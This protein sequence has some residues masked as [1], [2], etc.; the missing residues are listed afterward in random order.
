MASPTLVE[1]HLAFHQSHPHR[2]AF[3]L[4]YSRWAHEGQTVTP[5]MRW[6]EEDGGLQF[7]YGDLFQGKQPTWE[8]F[9]TSNLS[10]KTEL[11]RA[12]PFSES[13]TRPVME[14]IELG[15][16]LA[17]LGELEMHFLPEALGEHI[18][19]TDVDRSCRRMIIAGY[20]AQELFRAWPELEPGPPPTS[21]K[22]R[23]RRAILQRGIG[24]GLL[25]TVT[26]TLTRF[27]CPNHC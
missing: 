10:G 6:L 18:H 11:L 15:Y 4:G 24:L 9:Y 26:V 8:H 7:A 5:F 21:W 12:H 16:R 2:S 13:F 22:G 17:R 23:L 25:R 27:W 3:A 19:P 20:A 1:Q 14:D